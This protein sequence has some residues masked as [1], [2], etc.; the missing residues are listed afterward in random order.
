MKDFNKFKAS[1]SEEV[2]AQIDSESIDYA[3]EILDKKYEKDDI[4]SRYAHMSGYQNEYRTIAIL[5]RYH[6]WLNS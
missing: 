2:L 3:N 4:E 1:L 6:E 5:E